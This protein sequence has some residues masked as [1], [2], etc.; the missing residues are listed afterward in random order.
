MK[1]CFM[2]DLQLTLDKNALQ[3]DVLNWA[4]ADIKRKQPDF[5]IYVEDVNGVE[6]QEDYNSFI[7]LMNEI[8][9]PFLYISDDSNLKNHKNKGFIRKNISECKT[10]INGI[11]IFAINDFDRTISDKEFSELETADDNSIVFMHH[12][13]KNHDDES[14]N[15]LLNWRETHKKTMLF[16]GHL[17]SSLKDEN[18]VNLQSMDPDKAIGENPCIIYYD[19]NTKETRQAYYF[20]P[21]PTDIYNYFGISCYNPIRQI[22]FAIENKLK[23]L[24]L[25]PNCVDVNIDELKASI[26]RW[27]DAGGENLSIH[28]PDIGWANNNIVANENYNKLVEMVEKLNADRV[29]QHV[30]KVSVKEINEDFKILE[31]IC[32]YIA[33]RLNE[34][35]HDIVV[36][37]ENMHMTAKEKANDSRRFGYI[38]EECIKFMEVLAKSCRH[39]VGINFD[40][41]HA[42]NN[43]P[44]SK[45]YQIGTWLSL[46][47]KHIVGY[48]IHQAN[49]QAGI[50]E[51]H[52]PIKDIYDYPISCATFFKCWATG[53]VNKAPIIFQMK[54]E[55]AYHI[56]LKTFNK[57]KERKVFDIHSH[58]YYSHCG[59]D[60]PHELIN[61]AIQNGLSIFGICDHNHGIRE[62]KKQYID[63]I[64]SIAGQYADK[65][66]LYCGIEIATVPNFYD[67]ESSEEIKDF[68]YCLIEHITDDKSVVKGNLFEF[69]DKMGILCGIAH[70]DLFVYCDMYGF[71]YIEFFNTMAKKNI[72]WEMNV[73]YDSIHKY[74]EHQYVLDFM[75]TP[76]KQKIIKEAG[77][78]LSIGFDSHNHE[79]YDGYKVHEIYDFLRQNNFKT[80]CEI[81]K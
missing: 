62:R 67:I 14:Y 4:I 54:P 40:I 45:K 59:R 7:K 10:V 74:N 73:S 11:S 34:T 80:V 37:V 15:K 60:N 61:T 31:K 35:T 27:R 44:Y 12:P 30:P 38:P 25:R 49:Y 36:G 71:D 13:L 6:N 20:S 76:E 21:V 39:K 22:E 16:Y 43:A 26:N 46:I 9:I 63:E 29:T 79:E 64:K 42:R 41:G 32:E 58:T 2:C 8:G 1:I 65:I 23:Y 66:K 28:L 51:N 48:H 55:N 69:C 77:L 53:R 52:M 50:F 18:S 47:G 5:V 19:T 56:T 78:C 3:Y 17:Y 81:L 72:F 70:T 68:D 57:Y 24:E 75:K 33:D